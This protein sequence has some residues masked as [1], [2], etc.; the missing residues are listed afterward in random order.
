MSSGS[1]EYWKRRS[2]AEAERALRAKYNDFFI[3][4]EDKNKKGR[5]IYRLKFKLNNQLV[6]NGMTNRKEDIE[7]FGMRWL[8]KNEREADNMIFETM[9]LESED[10]STTGK[11]SSISTELTISGM[12]SLSTIEK[13]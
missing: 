3:V 13:S 8:R 10:L 2:A 11:I 1:S 9:V 12:Q 4:I 7:N 5:T 6:P